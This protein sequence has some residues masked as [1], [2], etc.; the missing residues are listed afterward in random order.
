MSATSLFSCFDARLDSA[1]W[2]GELTPATD[3]ADTREIVTIRRGAVPEV[4]PGAQPR[5][6]GLEAAG[7][8]ALLTVAGNARFLV[9]GGREIVVEALPGSTERNVRLFLLGSALGVLAYQRGLLPLHA[10]AVVIDGAAYAFTGQSGAGKSTLAAHF[11]HAGHRVL[12]D[13]VCVV[14]FDADGQPLAWPGL[15]RLK[16]WQDAADAFGHDTSALDRAVDGL[17]K[18]HVPLGGI[19][20]AP[21][22]LRRLY[23]LDRAAEGEGA[24]VSLAG[25]AAM[26]AVMANSYRGMYANILGVG[27]R[28]FAQCAALCGKIEVFAATR[29]WGFDVFE[30]EA[31]RLMTHAAEGR[32]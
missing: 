28:H 8:T 13:D 6:F 12:C 3:P 20:D 16:L 26:T 23:T 17:E 18:F 1:I 5:S 15:P 10:N 25:G 24:I 11:A 21:I 7:D 29:A 22:P 14:S 30:R 32:R 9:R 19:A 4:L 31:G 27:Q 2:L